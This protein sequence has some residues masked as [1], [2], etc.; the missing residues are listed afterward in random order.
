MYFDQT[1]TV[2]YLSKKSLKT[3]GILMAKKLRV[4]RIFVRYLKKVRNCWYKSIKKSVVI[5]VPP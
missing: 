4:V 3:I 1:D 5:K 2:S